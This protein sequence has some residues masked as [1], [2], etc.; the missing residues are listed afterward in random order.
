[1]SLDPSRV[2]LQILRLIAKRLGYKLRSGYPGITRQEQKRAWDLL[3]IERNNELRRD[4]KRRK[5]ALTKALAITQSNN[6]ASR[7]RKKE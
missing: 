2:R 5:R 3:H 4:A 1:M 6:V 7:D